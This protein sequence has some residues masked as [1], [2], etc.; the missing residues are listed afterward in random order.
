MEGRTVSFTIGKKTKWALVGAGMLILG[1]ILAAAFG[2]VPSL[3]GIGVI[4]LFMAIAGGLL[5]L[6]ML[7][8]A[9]VKDFENKGEV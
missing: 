5:V 2:P 1:G 9:I 4:G 6:V 7:V 3:A 8:L